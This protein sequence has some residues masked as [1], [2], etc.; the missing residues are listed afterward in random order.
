MLGSRAAA[1]CR[2][3]LD[4]RA[5][6]AAIPPTLEADAE[7]AAGAAGAAALA[8]AIRVARAAVGTATGPRTVADVRRAL[9]KA[10]EDVRRADRAG[11]GLAALQARVDETW[12]ALV[13]TLGHFVAED[14]PPI[15]EDELEAAAPAPAAAASLAA[16]FKSQLGLPTDEDLS[17]WAWPARAGSLDDPRRSR[18]VAATRLD[19]IS[20]S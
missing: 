15:D 5:A 9:H 8:A 10:L 7:R 6:E 2:A 1:A 11:P 18:G 12:R 4:D 19:R 20:T 13:P 14:H 16:A 3:F 17:S